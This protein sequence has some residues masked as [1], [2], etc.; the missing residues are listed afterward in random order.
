MR[1]DSICLRH[2]TSA[3]LYSALKRANPVRANPSI[4][5]TGRFPVMLRWSARSST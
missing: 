5:M 4:H 1:V 2:M 3:K